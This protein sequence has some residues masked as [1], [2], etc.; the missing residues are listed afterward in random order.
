MHKSL[1]L[2]TFLCLAFSATNS[3]QLVARTGIGGNVPLTKEQVSTV[4]GGKD[5]CEKSCGLNGEHTC[6]F[7]C[8]PK[9]CS[10]SCTNC[11]PRIGP[12]KLG[13]I[14]RAPI[15]GAMKAH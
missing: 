7:G 9:G 3:S 4:C 10:G 2:L 12:T 15:T 11:S 1:L 5:Y 14:V 13:H 6:D 8:G